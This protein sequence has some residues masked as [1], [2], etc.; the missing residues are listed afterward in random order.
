MDLTSFDQ[1]LFGHIFM[2]WKLIFFILTN[3]ALM[4]KI[5]TVQ[6]STFSDNIPRIVLIQSLIFGVFRPG[7]ILTYIYGMGADFFI[8]THRTHSG[9]TGKIPTVQN[10]T[11]SDNLPRIVPIQN[12]IFDVFLPGIFLRYIYVMEADFFH[13]N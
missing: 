10:S 6:N 11:F 13:T 12:R 9:L 3:S 2:E 7:V 4:G 1:E 5:P 8:L